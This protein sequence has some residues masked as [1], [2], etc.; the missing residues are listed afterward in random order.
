MIGV[1]GPPKIIY[2][3]GRGGF[4]YPE[5][6][7]RV[8]YYFYHLF[9]TLNWGSGPTSLC[10]P[11][12]I[13]VERLI[14][15]FLPLKFPCIV[16][17]KRTVIV[18][19]IPNVFFYGLQAYMRTWFQFVYVFDCSRNI[20]VGLALR[21]DTYWHQ[22]DVSEVL[23]VCFNSLII[24]VIFVGSGCVAIGF[25]VR[26]AAIKRFQMTIGY[27]QNCNLEVNTFRTTK[28]LLVLCV[29]YT[30]ACAFVTLP[31]VIPKFMVFPLFLEEP[32]FRSVGVFVYHIFKLVLSINASINFI[33][34]VVMNKN[35]RDT[36]L[37][38]LCRK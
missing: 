28:T 19:I 23:E 14:A 29:F 24:L 32:N 38:I 8:L 13:T 27:K 3:W 34:Y 18:V 35:F 30:G 20:S 16:T 4:E 6:T 11:V 2:E 7:A 21:S 31:A 36:F 15:V 26:L 17:P 33:I 1:N 12:L 5:E 25:K 37:S 22:K 9:D 10:I